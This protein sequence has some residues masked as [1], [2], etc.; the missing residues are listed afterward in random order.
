[1]LETLSSLAAYAGM[2]SILAAFGML[3]LGDDLRLYFEGLAAALDNGTVVAHLCNEPSH[4]ARR[5][6]ARERSS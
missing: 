3:L 5:A 6:S 1:M 2:I 4:F